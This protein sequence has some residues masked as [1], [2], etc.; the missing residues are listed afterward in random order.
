MSDD[1][2][3][4]CP[5]SLLHHMLSG[6]EFNLNERPGQ[7]LKNEEDIVSAIGIGQKGTHKVLRDVLHT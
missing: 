6:S 7:K 3:C 5:Q 1:V 2:Q 4:F